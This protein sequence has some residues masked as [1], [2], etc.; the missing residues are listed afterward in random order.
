MVIKDTALQENAS[1][2]QKREAQSEKQK[3]GE[4]N[5]KEKI[6]YF[7]EYYRMKLICLVLGVAMAVWL[8]YSVLGPSVE[9]ILYVAVVNDYWFDSSVE[10]MQLDLKEYLGGDPKWSNVQVDDMY[11]FKDDS[12]SDA[13]Q[14]LQ[15]LAA[16][17]FAGEVDLIVADE[18]QF[19][20]YATQEY[21][22]DLEALLPADLYEK[23]KGYFVYF[24]PE[25]KDEPVAVG[26]RL[27]ESAVFQEMKG[28]EQNPVVGIMANSNHT[29]NAIAAIRYFFEVTPEYFAE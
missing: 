3:W 4:M 1:I 28:Y 17:V 27:G 19:E 10:A 15:K 26:I 25:G 8:L 24:T 12:S 21:F 9:Q 20:V 22:Y 7:N 14:Y 11:Y 13:A 23:V 29:E 18:G 5:R 6:Q 2:Y 16:Y